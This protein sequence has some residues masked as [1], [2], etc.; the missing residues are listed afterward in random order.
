MPKESVDGKTL[1]AL[2]LLSED[3]EGMPE[4][5]FTVQD[6][7]DQI[8]ELECRGY[9]SKRKINGDKNSC[10]IFTEK[11]KLYWRELLKYASK[12]F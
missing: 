3:K 10:Y 12:K 8:K 2:S 7:L 9:A 11:G 6:L 1:I 4:I 5:E